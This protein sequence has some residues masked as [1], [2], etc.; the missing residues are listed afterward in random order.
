[1]DRFD[2][3]PKQDSV[4]MGYGVERLMER[5]K[6]YDKTE[7]P[8]VDGKIEDLTGVGITSQWGVTSTDLGASIIMPNGKLLSV[9]GDTFSGGRVGEGDWRSPVG[10]IGTGDANNP[11]KY[12]H[13]AGADADYARQLWP[14][15]HDDPSTGWSQGGISTMIPSDLLRVGDTLYLHAI[16]NH[17]FGNVAWTGIWSS[18]DNGESWQQMAQFPGQNDNGY[19]QCWSWDYNPDDGYVYVA[20]TGFQRDKGVILRRVHPDDLGDDSK[21]EGWGWANNKWG[22]G[23]APTPITPPG[24]NWGELTFRRLDKDKWI[25]GG[26]LDSQYALGY[27]VINSPTADLYKT[28]LQTPVVGS[29]WE[30]EDQ[31]HN[32]VAQL[33]GGY[34]LPGSKLDSPGGVGIVVSQWNTKKGVP[35]RAM[36]YK[37]TLQDTTKV[38]QQD[39]GKKAS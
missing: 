8:P 32:K 10:L 21:Y 29:T 17:G 22:W 18:K 5:I 9:F 4:V 14:Y 26:F 15:V 33:Y 19:A 12:D 24:E 13:A 34:I 25:L 35:Y 6:P 11:I 28:P 38:Q 7:L 30:N 36:Q 20:S 39:P 1:M 23:N 37:V 31:A 3:S 2:A 16:A 27:R